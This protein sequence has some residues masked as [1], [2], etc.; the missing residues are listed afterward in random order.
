[1]AVGVLGRK[2]AV[3]GARSL[4]DLRP[5]VRRPLGGFALEE[6][7]ELLVDE[8]RS[9]AAVVVR[10]GETVVELQRVQIPLRVRVLSRKYSSKPPS[11]MT[12]N[13]SFREAAKPGTAYRPQWTKIPRFAS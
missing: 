9:E 6:R 11:A 4:E 8:V 12:R 2:H 5:V 3:A 13:G 10:P 7:L 1:M